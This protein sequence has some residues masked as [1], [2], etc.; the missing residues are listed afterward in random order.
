MAITTRI[1]SCKLRQE[2]GVYSGCEAEYI[3]SGVTGASLSAAA[4]AAI[5]ATDIPDYGDALPASTNL[6]VDSIDADLAGTDGTNYEF[7]VKVRYIPYG[8]FL[9]AWVWKGSTS[10]A[11]TN[12]ARDIGGADI[13]V[14]YTYPDDYVAD[15]AYAGQTITQG[16]TVGVLKPQLELVG[17]GIVETNTPLVTMDSWLNKTNSTDWQGGQAGSWYIS[18]VAYTILD[19]SSSPRKYMFEVTAQ[20]RYSGWHPTAVFVDPVT[21]QPPPDL[22]AGLGHKTVLSYQNFDFNNVW[23]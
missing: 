6:Y 10:L 18:N 12:T 3:V 22:V 19:V 11:Q 4:V 8:E 13:T 1:R 15:P 2:Y 16:G 9:G 7:I 17:N 20:W 14:Q 23:S 21:G 5:T